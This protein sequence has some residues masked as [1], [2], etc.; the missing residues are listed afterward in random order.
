MEI[1]ATAPKSTYN[2][3]FVYDGNK[4]EPL[5][6]ER[7]RMKT[8]EWSLLVS[9]RTGEKG[10]GYPDVDARRYPPCVR[11]VLAGITSSCA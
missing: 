10:R 2:S 1:N 7:Y 5:N 4:M 11:E 3:H 8:G 9:M 6:K